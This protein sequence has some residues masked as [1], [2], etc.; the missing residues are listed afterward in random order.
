ML[1]FV[2]DTSAQSTRVRKGL[3]G[4]S[5]LQ[6]RFFKLSQWPQHVRLLVFSIMVGLVAGF[7]A[8]FF[9]Q[10]LNLTL[11]YLLHLPISFLEPGAA[12]PEAAVYRT[13]HYSVW[14][15]PIATLGGL[16]SGLLVFLLAPEAEGHGTDAM[17]ESFHLRGGYIRKR[18]PIIKLIASALT[19]GTGG[20]AGKEGPIAQIGSGFGS[21]MAALLGLKPQERRLLLLAGAAG[22]IGAIFQAPLGA[23]L[24]VPGVLYR[25][26]EYE[27]EAILPC[28]IS[29]I[30]A[31]SVFTEVFGR[32]ALFNPGAVSFSLTAELLPYAIFGVVC[33]GVGY[34]YIKVFY[35]MRDHI[36]ANIPIPKIFKPAIGGL[37]LGCVAVFFP[38]IIDGGYGWIQMALDGK[39][40]WST[41]LI[42]VFAKILATSFT[43]SSGGSGGVFG[44]SVFI[45]AMLGGAF[46]YFGHQ[47]FPTWVLNPTA[48]VL[49]GM[50][51]FF[52][53]VAK[54]PIASIIMACEMSASYTLL[55]PLMVVSTISY[56]LLGNTSLYEKQYSNR[57]DS[58]AHVGEFARGILSHMRVADAVRNKTYVSTL[59]ESLPFD[60]LVKIVTSS[61]ESYFPIV[62]GD[63]VM[64]GVLTINDI[65]SIMFEDQLSSLVVAK[66]VATTRVVSATPKDS[67]IAVLDKM[68]RLN[69]DELPVIPEAGPPKP[70]AM[71]SK[72]D[73]ITH[74]YETGGL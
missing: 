46:G 32:E 54:V 63:G 22:G 72:Q 71:I 11:K 17:I 45:G 30:V 4:H 55:V 38:Q 6:S 40:L 33:A 5:L 15:I 69:V 56:L 60:K 62:N 74:Y 3:D 36:F 41:M 42:L 58:P 70:L 13:S 2:E 51:G 66:D 31:Q 34:V 73:I 18:A 64:T 47:L 19:I 10:L 57:L 23:A 37:L 68:A 1:E 8:V 67:L 7:G 50:G 52:S 21:I 43:I 24:F 27:F 35:G 14:I 20:S 59:E 44:P 65:R 26:T 53:G 16:A 48:F 12:A 39:L 61:P 9:D 49:V 29:S 25:D 28:I